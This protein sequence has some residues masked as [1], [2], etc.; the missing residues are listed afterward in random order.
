MCW[1]ASSV[2]TATG[3]AFSDGA[4]T[5]TARRSRS[6]P[7]RP[8][9][10]RRPSPTRSR[11]TSATSPKLLNFSNDDFIRTTEER[12]ISFRLPGTSGRSWSRVRRHLPRR[13]YA[14]WYAVRDEAYY[15]E[16]EI[17]KTVRTAGRS[18]PS[19]VPRCEW[20]EE[21]SYFFRLSAWG[22]R[23]LKLYEEQP[24]F[25]RSGKPAQ[26]G[27]QLRQGRPERSF[28]QSDEPAS[29]GACRCPTIPSTSCTSGSTP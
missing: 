19:V 21:E 22:D 27:D 24:D 9:S 8:G 20:V 3:G 15:A 26:R 25:I 7:R 14:G 11:R 17:W 29:A 5:S 10:I 2:W 18:Q 4:P 28:D 12:H 23:L 6:P 16:S 13:L 1:P